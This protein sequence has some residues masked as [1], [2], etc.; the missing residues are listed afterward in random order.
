MLT[1]I[2]LITSTQ[3]TCLRF[4]DIRRTVNRLADKGIGPSIHLYIYITGT[5]TGLRFTQVLISKVRRF[6]HVQGV[7]S[8]IFVCNLNCV[9]IFL[10]LLHLPVLLLLH[11]LAFIS[12]P[13]FS[14]RSF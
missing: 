6:E 4:I 9:L 13:V 14:R 8:R 5:T 10:Q 3:Q 2:L 11:R 12:F 7:I 1:E